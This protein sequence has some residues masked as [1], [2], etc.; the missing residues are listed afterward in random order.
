MQTLDDVDVGH[1]R[2]DRSSAD[3][4]LPSR[5]ARST[6]VRSLAAHLDHY[7]VEDVASASE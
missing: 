6:S 3:P 4:D 5:A 1:R 7:Q 2:G